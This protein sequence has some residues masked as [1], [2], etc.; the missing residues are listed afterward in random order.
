[1]KRVKIKK[2][3]VPHLDF[4]RLG[5]T[6]VKTDGKLDHFDRSVYGCTVLKASLTGVVL[7]HT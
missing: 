7:E 6:P 5:T 4:N 2:K 1:M 3:S